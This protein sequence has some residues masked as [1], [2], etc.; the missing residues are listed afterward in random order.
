MIKALLVSLSLTI[1]LAQPASSASNIVVLEDVAKVDLLPGW[2]TGAGTHMA[3][4]RI[5]LAP[6]WK[7][8]W[9]APGD[10]GIPP[11]FDWAGSTN[12][13]AVSFHWPT[14]DVFVANGM[15]SIGYHDQLI[16]PIE[17]S[18]ISSGPI[19]LRASIELGVCEE[20]CLPMQVKL[21]GEL[22]ERDAIDPAIQT[23]L[24]N[25]PVSAR[26]GGVRSATCAVE[27]IDD[28][29]RVTARIDMPD[30]G[31]EIAVLE[32]PDKSIWVSQSSMS[33]QAG[34]LE[35]T[36]EMVPSNTAPFLLNRS[37]I[38]ITVLGDRK[39]VEIVGCPAS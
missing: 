8:Y 20:I 5:Q 17:F 6:G 18:P 37:E 31:S 28:G 3:A 25:Q 21:V 13:K 14:P 38:R 36:A 16:L 39:A 10:A 32:V 27:P 24:A 33:R 7:T 19:A 29:L 12:L 26:A 23:S 9:R 2:R 4:I 30:I 15:R 35:A 22:T 1:S 34:V 11:R